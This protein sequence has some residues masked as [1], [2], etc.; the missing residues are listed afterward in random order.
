[1]GVHRHI[2]ACTAVQSPLENSLG[3]PE[4]N[5]LARS[6]HGPDAEELAVCRRKLPSCRWEARY[7]GPDRGARGGVPSC[8]AGV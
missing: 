2:Y 7:P 8:S 3:E 6:W 5:N 4:L 1:M